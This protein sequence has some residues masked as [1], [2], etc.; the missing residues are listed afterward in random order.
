V[1][2]AWD[3]R[4]CTSVFGVVKVSVKPQHGRLSNHLVDAT[5]PQSRFGNSGHCLGRPTKG[6]AVY[7][8]P[9]PGFHGTDTFTLDLSWPAIGKQATDMYTVTVQ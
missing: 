4:Y 2:T 7:Y 1:H 5:I 6:F 8:T 3:P 9:A